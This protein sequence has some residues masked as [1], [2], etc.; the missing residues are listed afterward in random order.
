[1]TFLQRGHVYI[2]RENFK[3]NKNL[4]FMKVFYP[5]IIFCKGRIFKIDDGEQT[6]STIIIRIVYGESRRHTCIL[7]SYKWYWCAPKAKH[8][9]LSCLD[10]GNKRTK[11]NWKLKSRVMWI[12]FCFSHSTKWEVNLCIASDSITIII[13]TMEY[14]CRIDITHYCIWYISNYCHLLV[15]SL[16]M[17][18]RISIT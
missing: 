9:S 7:K 10:V 5:I 8:N 17:L 11:R 1:M 15:L 6:C 18:D 12:I 2:E 13:T 4:L 3:N 14:T 16:L